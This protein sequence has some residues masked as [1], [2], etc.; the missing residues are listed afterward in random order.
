MNSADETAFAQKYGVTDM[1]PVRKE[2]PAEPLI[3]PAEWAE[4]DAARARRAQAAAEAVYLGEPCK[5]PLHPNPLVCEV[6]EMLLS[7]E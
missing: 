4:I 5:P 7:R 3:T 2:K 1:S 6:A